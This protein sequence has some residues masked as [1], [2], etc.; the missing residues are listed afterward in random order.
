[1]S[2]GFFSCKHNASFP[3]FFNGCANDV[4]QAKGPTSV[5]TD[6]V[7]PRALLTHALPC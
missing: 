1:V 5:P 4:H 7:H 3:N 6:P 2:L